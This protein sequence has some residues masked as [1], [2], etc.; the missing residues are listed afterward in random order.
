MTSSSLTS[1]N[2][3]EYCNFRHRN[4]IE[5]FP[6]H[7]VIQRYRALFVAPVGP[8]WGLMEAYPRVNEHRETISYDATIIFLIGLKRYAGMLI[9]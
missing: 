8:K 1:I 5:P 6:L 4:P 9:I 2:I 7:Q 3:A